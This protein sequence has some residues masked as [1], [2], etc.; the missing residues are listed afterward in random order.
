MI[1]YQLLEDVVKQ[2]PKGAFLTTKISNQ[3]NTMTIG[4]LTIG[5]VW[6]IDLI[7]V[8]VRFSRYTYDLIEN[9]KYFTVSIPDFKGKADKLK[10]WGETSGR[11]YE[12]LSMNDIIPTK[13]VDG[14]LIKG[15]QIH[16]ECEKVYDQPMDPFHLDTKLRD[17]FYGD[18]GD[19]HHIYYGK[20][21][22]M[23]KEEGLELFPGE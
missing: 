15:C 16:I 2:M 4:W 9:T 19:Y 8:Y 11:D 7:T 10:L 6:E 22:D 23:Y 12:K 21:I 5:R 3:T 20:I 1:D 13:S 18:E 14:I 17:A